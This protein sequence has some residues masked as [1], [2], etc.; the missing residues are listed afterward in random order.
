VFW[1]LLANVTALVWVSLRHPPSLGDRLQAASLLN[2]AGAIARATNKLLPGDATVQ[3]LRSLAERLLGPAAADRLLDRYARQQRHPLTPNQRADVAL[4]QALE[5]E[6]T[7]A[8]GAASARLVLTSALHGAGLRLEEVVELFDE[9]SQRL[10]FNR[11]LLEAM[12]DNMSQGI[13][14]VDANM[15]LVAWNQ[16]YLDMFQYPEGFVQAG[17]PI[18]DMIRFN[19][20]RGWCGP[21]D[22]EVHAQ[23]RLAYM[24]SGKAHVS[25]RRRADGRWIEGRGQPLPDGGFVMTFSDVTAHKKIQDDLR[26]INETLEQRVAER[27]EQLAR[28]TAQAEQANLSKTRFVAAA[29]HDLLQPLNAARLFNAALR[30]RAERSKEIKALAERVDSSLHA[31][32]EL[33]D[34]LLDISRLDAGAVSPE[35]VHVPAN[36]ILEALREQFAPL[37]NER[38]IELRVHATR[39]HVH[40]DPRML[41]RILQNFMA[42]ALRYTRS[43]CVVIGCRSRSAG[44][45]IE[46]QVLDTGPGIAFEN[47]RAI[48]EEFRRLDQQSPWGEKGLGLGLSICDRIAKILGATLTLRS[49]PGHGSTFGIRVPRSYSTTVTPPAPARPARSPPATTL[50]GLRVLCV[51]DDPNILDGMRELL[52][53]WNIQVTCATTSGEAESLTGLHDPDVILVDFHLHGGP[54]GLDLLEK[55]CAR[56]L[57]GRV[58]TG[59]LVTA[60][61]SESLAQSARARGFDVLRKPVRP[62]ALRALIAALARKSSAAPDS[63]HA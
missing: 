21:G 48:F 11:E 41:K 52:N 56:S 28:A 31:A 42:N 7:G 51:D 25:E 29:S 34:A 3:D 62:A 57:D 22:P 1:S 39:L 46:F 30:A 43:G 8:L 2:P 32:E 14:V 40:S 37:A 18:A 35:P 26:E 45:E 49:E 53:R 27:T 12:M 5:R 6:L 36:T 54:V 10:R 50:H 15:R 4:L 9:A 55:L 38:G 61:A 63:R 60:N 24:R 44:R 47:Q 58:R 19:A 59:A 17:R 16:R 23:K 33:L 13:S 20:Q